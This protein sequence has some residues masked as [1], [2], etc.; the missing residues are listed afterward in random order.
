MPGRPK[1][2][3]KI[4]V[5][6]RIWATWMPSTVITGIIAFFRLCLTTTT[7]SRRPLA[8]DLEQGAAG[9]AH[10]GRGG[11][12]A[13]DE[14]GQQELGE[15]GPGVDGER[16]ELDGRAPAPPDRGQEHAEG[17]DPEAGHR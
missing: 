10:D 16:G 15:V 13:Q 5:P 12:D 4:T 1:M 9:E 2:L 17:G 7:R 3:S 6:P 8:Q 14:R 11:G